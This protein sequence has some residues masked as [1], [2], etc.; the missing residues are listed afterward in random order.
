MGSAGDVGEGT[1]ARRGSRRD[2][3][4]EYGGCFDWEAA[5]FL[6]AFLEHRELCGGCGGISTAF[7]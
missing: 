7:H 6:E 3:A 4:Y 5:D 2:V 1:G